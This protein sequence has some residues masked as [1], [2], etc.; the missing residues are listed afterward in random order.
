MRFPTYQIRAPRPEDPG[1]RMPAGFNY[2]SKDKACVSKFALT[3][4]KVQLTFKQGVPYLRF[5]TSP[6]KPGRLVP[7]RSATEARLLSERICMC[8]IRGGDVESC[9]PMGTQL[10]RLPSRSRKRRR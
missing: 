8:K 9:L 6:N 2:T 10:G 3:K 1:Y 5:C 4:C 7:V